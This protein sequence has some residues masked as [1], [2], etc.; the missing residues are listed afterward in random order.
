MFMIAYYKSDTAE[1]MR[2]KN[3]MKYQFGRI[4]Q[5]RGNKHIRKCANRTSLATEFSAYTKK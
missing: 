3:G 4:K 5:N 1:C 2:I